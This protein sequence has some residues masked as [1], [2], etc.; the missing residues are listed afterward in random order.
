M[1]LNS[2]IAI[3]LF[4]RSPQ[5]EAVAK[6]WTGNVALNAQISRKLLSNTL[7]HLHK[8]PFPVF[9][10][11]ETLQK[12]NTFGQRLSN[13]FDYVFAKGYSHVIAVGND[14]AGL[15]VEWE[16]IAQT[17]Y[18][19][20]NIIGPDHRGGVYL[21]GISACVQHKAVFEKISWRGKFV[22]DQLVTQMDSPHVLEGVGDIN[23]FDDLVSCPILFT[24]IRKFLFRYFHKVIQTPSVQHIAR[25][26]P[27]L[28]A[29]PIQIAHASA[30]I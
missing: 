30:L 7:S 13:A 24:A 18:S 20:K 4:S 8:A 29:P 27:Q 9:M 3:L 26:I 23:T 11:D 12:G 16:Q 21:I 19:G 1:S 6:R 15:N 10:V 28:R 5:R 25:T 2:D 22:F 14:S 17:L